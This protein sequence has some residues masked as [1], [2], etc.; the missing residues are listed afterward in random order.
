MIVWRTLLAAALFALAAAVMLAEAT[1]QTG[2]SAR[3]DQAAPAA[4]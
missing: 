4:H 3:P 1:A 2:M